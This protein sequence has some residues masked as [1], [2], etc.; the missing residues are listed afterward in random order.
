MKIPVPSAVSLVAKNIGHHVCAL[1]RINL[2]VLHV[3]HMVLAR[4]QQGSELFDKCIS[5]NTLPILIEFSAFLLKVAPIM[6]GNHTILP[7]N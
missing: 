4:D 7:Q 1:K 3:S 6:I 5:M 2:L